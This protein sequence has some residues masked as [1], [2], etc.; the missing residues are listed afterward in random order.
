MSFLTRA[1]CRRQFPS[2]SAACELR[3]RRT[4]AVGFFHFYGPLLL[5]LFARSRGCA[6]CV[7]GMLALALRSETR[8]LQSVIPPVAGRRDDAS[9]VECRRGPRDLPVD[10]NAA[11]GFTTHASCSAR[12]IPNASVNPHSPPFY[13]ILLSILPCLRADRRDVTRPILTN[14]ARSDLRTGLC[15]LRVRSHSGTGPWSRF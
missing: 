5:V 4:S 14:I 7:A 8:R 3:V 1:A 9:G 13:F 11:S 2:C 12:A 15:A 10:G 6:R